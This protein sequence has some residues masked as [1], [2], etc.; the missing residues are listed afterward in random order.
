MVLLLTALL[1]ALVWLVLICFH[2]RFWQG[3]PILDPVAIAGDDWP[4]VCIVVP[5]R[6]E[7]GSV[8]ACVA[9][10][11]EQSYPGPLSL[12]LV[13]DNST[14]GTGHLAR[15]VPDPLRRLTVVTGG[16]RPSG[17]SGKLWAVAQG[18]AEVRRQVPADS[19][20]VFLTDADITHDPAHIATLVAKARTDG[21]DMVSEMV[22]LNCA[23]VAEQMLVPAFVFF[24]ALL[25]PFA[26]VNDP[27]SRVA[28]A[29]GGSILIH[30]EALARIGGIESL[31]G[32]LIDDCTLAM[33]VKRSGGR[34]YLG[35]SRLARSIRPYPHP[36]DIWRMVARTAYVQLR[37]SPLMLVG[38]VLGMALVWIAPVLLALFGHGLPRLLG[39]VAWVVSMASFV[40]TL[41]RFRLSPAWALLLPLVAVFY[42]AATIGSAIDHHRG[43]GVVWK[44]RAYREPNG[45][46]PPK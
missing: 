25:Y 21:L 46:A 42:T 18:V 32:A 6:D 1:C 20:Y 43:R 33:H 14:D 41:R 45:N 31:R 24:F 29:A 26:R 40:P 17:W 37:Y 11:L 3:G 12:V 28:G 4:P 36:A 19:G 10:L 8:Q 5:A 34:L 7:A 39:A 30:R 2:G 16:E 15:A 35:H 38:T 44:S 27:G 22:A 9:S 13:D 23:S